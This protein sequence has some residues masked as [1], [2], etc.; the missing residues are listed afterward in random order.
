MATPSGSDPTTTAAPGVSER[1]VAPPAPTERPPSPG[2]P[3]PDGTALRRRLDAVWRDPRLALALVVLFGA[4]WGALSGLWVPRGPLTTAEGL[5]TM[6]VS[7]GVGVAAGL[8]SRSRWAMLLAPVAFVAAL[9]L[10]RLGF[11]GPTVDA[12]HLSTYGILALVVGRGVH[13]MLALAPMVLG[14]AL[15]AGLARRLRGAPA[16]ATRR[17]RAALYGRRSVTGL[18]ALG[19]L[20]FAVAVARPAGTD[21]ILGADGEPLPGS[22]A[23]LTQVEVGGHDLGLMIRG[24]STRNPV[25]LFV[26]GGPG[27]SELGAM[28]RHLEGLER[29]FTV[30]TWDQRGTGR[31]YRELDPTSTLTFE[32]AVQDTIDVTNHL[33]RRF[34]QD[35]IVLVAQSYGS[36]AGVRAVQ[37][38]P[39]LYSAYVGV[40][41]MVSPAATDRAFYRATLDWARSRGDDALVST[42]TEQG[43]PPYDS[44][45]DYEPALSHEH[46]IWPY[47]RSANSEGQGGFSENLFVEEYTLLE[48]LHNLGAFLD[49]F[50]AVYPQL[51]ALDLRRTAPSL[52]VPVFL[53][54]GRHEAPGRAVYA[55]EWFERLRAPAKTRRV[56]ATSGHRP[57]WEQPDAFTRFM[58]DEVLTVAR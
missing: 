26:A 7:L 5:V 43:P 8:V 32:R 41:Q 12:P 58:R 57:L 13:G 25:L 27:G 6:L 3:P 35:R 56:F 47:D 10:V 36:L 14:A 51:Q 50:S 34:G 52:D 4:A 40:G 11:D 19:L 23:E 1:A 33:R 39:E 16:P 24:H 18:A 9:E 53:A 21:P 2:A 37:R 44:V 49:T 38:A 45:L 42:L 28:R 17:G 54:Q 15:G 30:V 31:S 20:L 22:V 55:D 48:Q 29:H 46:D